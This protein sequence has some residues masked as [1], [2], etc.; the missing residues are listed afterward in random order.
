M[1]FVEC[2]QREIM[3][4][5]VQMAYC[6]TIMHIKQYSACGISHFIQEK[7]MCTKAISWRVW[8]I[9]NKFIELIQYY[10]AFYPLL[11]IIEYQCSFITHQ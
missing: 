3:L 2:A 4:K 8:M 5:V 9:S 1:L 10:D 7:K 11:D 6:C